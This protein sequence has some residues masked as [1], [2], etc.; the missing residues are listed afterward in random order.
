MPDY[1]YQIATGWDNEAG[2]TNMESLTPGAGDPIP[3]SSVYFLVQASPRYSRGQPRFDATGGSGY[4]GFKV[5]KWN[6]PVVH[7]AA[8]EWLYTNYSGQNTIR[9]TT[10]VRD[11]YSNWN[12][13]TSM[14]SPDELT[15]IDFGFFE[16]VIIT[17][18]L[19]STT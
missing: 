15:P 16:D 11:S 3:R 5:V 12:V 4:V 8:Y 18:K 14:L 13:F 7:D 2:F 17:H 10:G 9:T 1:E 6:L 19:R